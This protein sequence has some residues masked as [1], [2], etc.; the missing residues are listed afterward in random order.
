MNG[1]AVMFSLTSI[2]GQG[3]LGAR[4]AHGAGPAR[5]R[6]V[7]PDPGGEA[8]GGRGERRREL[9]KVASEICNLR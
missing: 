8:L 7:K 3:R 4:G 9:E 1:K 6:G 2:V 5:H